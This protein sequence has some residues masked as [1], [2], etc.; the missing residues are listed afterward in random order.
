MDIKLNFI[1]RSN[2]T[3]NSEIVIFQKNA[4]ASFDEIAVAWK[5]IRYC[6]QGD[7]HPFTYEH[8]VCV[9]ASDSYGNYMPQIPAQNGQQYEVVLSTSGDILQLSPNPAS[10]PNEIEI[11]NA[12]T[13]GAVN[14]DI[15]R[16]GSLLA[17]KTNISPGEKAVFEFKPSIFIGVASQVVEGDVMNS[18]IISDINTELS[19]L[20]ISS[21]DIVMT[22]GGVG[23]N[24]TAFQFHLENVVLVS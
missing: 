19:L 12:L 5:V 4:A 1:N 8:D 13:K 6:G 20:G 16:S 11:L 15:F 9:A 18:A 23:A 22:G 10:S 21:A 14:G 3:N 24:A 2:D 17:T 7:H